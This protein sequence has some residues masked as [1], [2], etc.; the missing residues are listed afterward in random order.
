MRIIESLYD[1]SDRHLRKLD[2]ELNKYKM[3]LEADN[4]GITEILERRALENENFNL[5]T[6]RSPL[7]I[8]LFYKFFS[9][10]LLIFSF[11]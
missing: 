1:V 8:L 11:F 5:E 7:V 9:F 3:E 6:G 10:K 2:I 4:D